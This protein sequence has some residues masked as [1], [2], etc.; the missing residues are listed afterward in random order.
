MA[1]ILVTGAGGFIGRALCAALG[2]HEH[3]VVAGVRR[4]PPPDTMPIPGAETRILGDIVPGRDWRGELDG[5]D[6]LVHLAQRAHRRRAGPAEFADEPAAAAALARAAARAGIRRLVYLSSIKA[7]GEA[8]APG[9][10][11][12]ADDPPRPSDAY[13]RGKLATEAALRRAAAET[14]LGLVILRPPLVYGPGVGANF[15]ALVRLAGSNLPLPFAAVANRRS[16][17]FVDNLAQVAAAAAL[18]PAATGHVLLVRDDEDLSTPALIRLLARAQG[19]AARLFAVPD[20]LFAALRAVPGLGPAVCRLTQSL[21]VDDAATRALL[22]W[23]P[24]IAAATGL[25]A[26]ARELASR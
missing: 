8:T 7:M 11:F 25:A 3:A 10:P 24:P 17:I 4:P 26:T 9:R 21:Q 2:A 20:G 16:L 13:G 12:R 14:G 15:R 18:H 1:R 19:R 6:I 5:A 23:R 22:S